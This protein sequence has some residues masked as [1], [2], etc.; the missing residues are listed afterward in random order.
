M[1]T[2]LTREMRNKRKQSKRRK[3]TRKKEM[4]NRREKAK[5]TDTRP[6]MPEQ[7][8]RMHRQA[9][10]RDKDKGKGDKKT[11]TNKARGHTAKA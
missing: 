11:P 9:G 7:G 4:Y 10:E 5:H 3:R 2:R 1:Q 8:R 6:P